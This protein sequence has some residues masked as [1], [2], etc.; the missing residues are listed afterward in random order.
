MHLKDYLDT[1][2]ISKT[3]FASEFEISKGYACD[4][5]NGNAKPSL[6][7]ASRILFW[8]DYAITIQDLLGGGKKS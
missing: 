4:L 6:E 5:A 7:L 1:N 3:Q 2:G 8:S